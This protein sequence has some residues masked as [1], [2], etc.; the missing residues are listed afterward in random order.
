MALLRRWIQ[1]AATALSNGYLLFPSSR[2]IYQGSLKSV[3][4]PG[5]NC[6]SCPAATAACP[7][8]A[9]QAFMAGLRP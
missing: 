3:C 9:L 1:S 6:Y 5:L 4:A 7:I 8:G 2:A